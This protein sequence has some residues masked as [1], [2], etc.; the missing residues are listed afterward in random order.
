MKRSYLTNLLLLTLM[1]VLL[2]QLDRVQT[3]DTVTTIGGE[4][5]PSMVQ[6]ITVNRASQNTIEMSKTGKGWQLQQPFSAMASDSRI[7]M[8]LSLLDS[9]PGEQFAIDDELDLTPFG[10]AKPD[11]TIRFNDT[12]FVFGDTEQL[13]GQRYLRSGETI[14]LFNDA[15]SPLLQASASGFIENRLF[16][17]SSKIQSLTLPYRTEQTLKNKNI[18]LQLH[19]GQWQSTDNLSSADEL[20]AMANAWQQAYA[21]QVSPNNE[22]AG[23]DF[24]PM[25]F[26]FDNGDTLKAYTRLTA[27]GL[28]VLIPERQLQYQFPA[29]T[30]MRLFPASSETN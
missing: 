22:A 26:D 29:S 6:K 28:S 7:N 12:A 16:A 2:W 21:M 23:D 25:Q 20:T 5:T 8:L 11:L 24:L 1:M 9:I 27:Q 18:T 10:L 14:Y 3:P 4:L 17:N 19:N 13:S 30:A 15:I